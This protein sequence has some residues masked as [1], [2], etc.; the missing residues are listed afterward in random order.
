M[1]DIGELLFVCWSLSQ[2]VYPRV[3]FLDESLSIFPPQTLVILQ[4]RL[5]T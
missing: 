2:P 5:K 4:L 3:I 1:Q